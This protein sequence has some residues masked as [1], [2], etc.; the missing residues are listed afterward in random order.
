MFVI[1][2]KAG[3]PPV[4]QVA[5]VRSAFAGMTIQPTTIALYPSTHWR[6]E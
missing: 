1:P 6:R 5:T 3:I 2:A 4:R